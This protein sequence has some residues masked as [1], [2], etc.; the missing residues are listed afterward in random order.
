[1][2]PAR[3]PFDDDF[4]HGGDAADGPVPVDAP[5]DAPA[6]AAATPDLS[7][8][9]QVEEERDM[10]AE[11][12]L[13]NLARN[14]YARSGGRSQPFPLAP[15]KTVVVVCD[16]TRSVKSAWRVAV[17]HVPESVL[18][19]VH[20]ACTLD[21][22]L[23]LMMLPS[24]RVDAQGTSPE[25]LWLAVRRLCAKRRVRAL[26]LKGPRKLHKESACE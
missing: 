2:F 8:H 1:M 13:M 25:S 9:L 24:G 21:V 12:A 3:T 20:G 5:D 7:L 17:P 4:Q 19:R 14:V 11:R 22:R 18:R 10:K 23:K 15:G 26:V 6:A 16:A